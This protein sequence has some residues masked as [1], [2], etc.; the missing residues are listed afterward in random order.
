MVTHDYQIYE[1]LYQE[2]IEHACYILTIYITFDYYNFIMIVLKIPYT[3]HI[4]YSLCFKIPYTFHI[5]YSL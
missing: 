4:H 1:I 5:H 2:R 3:F